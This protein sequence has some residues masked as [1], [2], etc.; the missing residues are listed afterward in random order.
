MD[1]HQQSANLLKNLHSHHVA[2]HFESTDLNGPFSA[3]FIW[4]AASVTTLRSKPS[5]LFIFTLLIIIGIAFFLSHH[6]FCSM[7]NMFFFCM[8][9]YPTERFVTKEMLLQA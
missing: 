7:F 3:R 4:G 2:Q 9:F 1:H 5:F 8:G 6:Y